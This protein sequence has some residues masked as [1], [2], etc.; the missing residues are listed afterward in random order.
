[1]AL[2]ATTPG[3]L[4]SRSTPSRITCSTPSDFSKRGPVSDIRIVSTLRGSNPGSTPP[5]ATAVRISRADPISRISASATS[6]DDEHGSAPCSGGTRARAAAALL[7]RGRQI[8]PRALERR[9]QAEEHAGS[10]RHQ[11]REGQ[12]APVDADERAVYAD[13]RQAGRV[14]REQRANPEQCRARA[15][16]RRRRATARR[17]RSAADARCGRAIRRARH[18][19]RSRAAARWRAPS[20]GSRRCAQAISSTNV[21]APTSTKS[22]VRTLRTST[23]LTGS[24]LKLPFGPSE[25]G[26]LR[27][28]SC[29]DTLHARLR[30]LQRHAWL[31]PRGR[32]EVVPLVGGVRI[33]LERRPHLR[34]R[35]ELREVEVAEHADDGE[36]VAAERNRF[37][38]DLRVAV[39]AASP[40]CHGSG[41]RPSGPW[42][43]PLRR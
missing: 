8:R 7:E 43:D 38:E 29:A 35:A 6:V 11:E 27:P 2:A 34:R 18:A 4:R 30:L 3:T 16:A 5:S 22:D 21:T 9:E 36:R 25:P 42:R 37:P 1:M 39:E 19:S 26:N 12:H 32:L 14:H 17:S 10:E 31:Q 13:S 28:N 33:E 41:P 20:A 40:T 23:S 15:R 24:T